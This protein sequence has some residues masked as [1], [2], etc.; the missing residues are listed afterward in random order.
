MN[1]L[2]DT[3][4]IL[5]YL[6]R[7]P[8]LGREAVEVIMDAES[9][10]V[11]SITVFETVIKSMLGK[12][13]APT[14]FRESIESKGFKLLSFEAVQAEAVQEFVSLVRHDPFDRMLL[15]QAK[16]EGLAFLTADQMLLDLNLDFVVDARM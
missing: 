15:A 8:K 13:E 14:N 3:Q 10:Y 2:L 7:N 6:T 4:A 9:V 16:T 5:W 11:S 12:L 1:L